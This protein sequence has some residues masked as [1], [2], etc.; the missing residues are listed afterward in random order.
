MSTFSMAEIPGRILYE[1]NEILVFHKP[2]GLAVQHARSGSMDLNSALLTYLAAKEKQAW[3]AGTGK[4]GQRNEIPYLGVVHRLDQPVEG[5][6]VFAKT[7]AA[8]ASL[9]RQV[10][11][12][13]M[14]KEYM[15]VVTAEAPGQRDL[16]VREVPV[17][18]SVPDTLSGTDPEW[19][20]HLL[21]DHLRKDGRNNRTEIVPAGTKDAKKAR[22]WYRVIRAAGED[23]FILQI[24]L[25][26]GRFHQIRAQLS[27]AGMPIL[28]DRKY[29]GRPA[30]ALALCAFSLS[31]DHPKTGRRMRFRLQERS[32]FISEA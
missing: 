12:G 21:E 5:I 4:K 31:F 6:L 23:T 3:D 29:G 7:P 15:A 9:G 28:G 8:A 30:D 18:G 24:R 2:G 16:L 1:D 25:E 13:R 17:S 20:G 32:C 10:Q 11:D 27:H 14:D 22:L 26:T 19:T